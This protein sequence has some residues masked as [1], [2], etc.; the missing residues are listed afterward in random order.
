[1]ESTERD[2]HRGMALAQD[3]PADHRDPLFEHLPFNTTILRRLRD[4]QDDAGVRAVFEHAIS[5]K[6]EKR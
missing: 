2:L 1:M 4:S 5:Y 3:V 6:E